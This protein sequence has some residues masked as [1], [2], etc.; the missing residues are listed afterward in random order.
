MTTDKVLYG[1]PNREQYT[2]GF[3]HPSCAGS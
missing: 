1:R 2:L 3:A